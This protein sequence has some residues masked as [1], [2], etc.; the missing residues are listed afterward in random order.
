[1][2][3]VRFVCVQKVVVLESGSSVLC[4]R[5]EDIEKLRTTLADPEAGAEQIQ[6]ALRK[7]SSY[8]MSG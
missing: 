1:M 4:F 8:Y 7:L 3:H 5:K 2:N 6:E